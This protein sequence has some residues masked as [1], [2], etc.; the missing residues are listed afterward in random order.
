MVCDAEVW[1]V[2]SSDT[3]V[4]APVVKGSIGGGWGCGA[5]CG[6]PE[7][8]SW[9]KARSCIAGFAVW[10]VLRLRVLHEAARRFAQDDSSVGSSAVLAGGDV[11]AEGDAVGDADGDGVGGKGVVAA[12]RDEDGVF[13]HVPA[14]VL[15]VDLG[16][17]VADE[18]DVY[19]S[20][21]G[22][23][24]AAVFVV[25]GYGIDGV[26]DAADAGEEVDV[27]MEGVEV[28]L[29]SE[30]GEYGAFGDGGTGGVGGA[31]LQRRGDG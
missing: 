10:R 2:C 19:A 22:V 11:G 5:G 12:L 7:R 17:E 6:D 21:D 14:L 1:A 18:V 20:T 27:G 28:G 9:P 30:A 26:D 25:A 16:L 29:G 23:G 13:S 31:E 24:E 8:L 3:V 15:E 4:D